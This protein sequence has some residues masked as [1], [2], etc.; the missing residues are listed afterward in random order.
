MTNENVELIRRA[1]DAYAR[2]ELPAMLEF[3][4]PELEWTYLDPALK[5]PKPKVCRG[6]HELESVLAMWA[7]QG[8]QAE[9]EEIVGH[10]D[11]VIVTVHTPGIDAYFERPGDDRA[12][13]VLTV[14]DGRIVALR[15]CRNRKEAVALAGVE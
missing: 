6:R 3:I 5:R 12:Y 11:R 10:G 2:G 4:D 13:S 8:F 14:R 15:D 9:I 1:Y 7:Q